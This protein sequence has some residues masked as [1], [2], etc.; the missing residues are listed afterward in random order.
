VISGDVDQSSDLRVRPRLGDDHPT[1][2]VTDQDHGTWLGIDDQF[3]RAHISRQ[4]NSR[5]LYDAD[6]EAV[7]LQDVV[8]APP[9]RPVMRYTNNE[10]S[11]RIGERS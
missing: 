4:R 10:L 7:L 3:G 8:D 11:S 5:I 2:G 6:V 1:L 9:A